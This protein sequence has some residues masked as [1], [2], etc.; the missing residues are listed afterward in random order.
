MR[1]GRRL[2]R[3]PASARRRPRARSST[4]RRRRRISRSVRAAGDAAEAPRRGR[5]D[6]ADGQQARARREQPGRHLCPAPRPRNRAAGHLPPPPLD[7][8]RPRAARPSTARARA[9]QG[10]AAHGGGDR[11]RARGGR[12]GRRP[13]RR[14]LGR[15]F[16]QEGVVPRDVRGPRRERHGQAGRGTIAVAR[17]V[18]AARVAARHV[19]GKTKTQ[20]ARVVHE[21]AQVRQVRRPA[22]DGGLPLL[23][24]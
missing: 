9:R 12:R 5:G 6:A 2:K 16:C 10:G 4:G 1:G 7:S 18:A 11:T 8:A 21:G 24:G 3:R 15:G 13:L 22:R 14:R 23:Q 17:R 19:Y 20:N